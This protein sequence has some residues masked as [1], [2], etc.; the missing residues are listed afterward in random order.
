MIVR[1]GELA[2]ITQQQEEDEAHKYTDKE[3][4]EMTSTSIGKA[5]IFVSHILSLQHFLQSFILQNLGVASKVTTLAMDSIFF[6]A[7]FLLHLQAV[8]RVAGKMA[9]WT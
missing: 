1:D 7:D 4:L 8:F 6:F 3:Q 5:L 9:L 2:T